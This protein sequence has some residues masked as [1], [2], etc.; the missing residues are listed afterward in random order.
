MLIIRI[1]LESPGLA[2]LS[3]LLIP[4]GLVLVYLVRRKWY[5]MAC[6]QF[7]G[8]GTKPGGCDRYDSNRVTTSDPGAGD[9]VRIQSN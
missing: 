5:C 7:L 6:G 2:M 3:L 4:P 1:G 9:A 8:R